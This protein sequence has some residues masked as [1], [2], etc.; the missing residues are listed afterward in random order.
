MI[1]Y[2]LHML[3]RIDLNH[4]GCSPADH[5]GLAMEAEEVII[6]EVVVTQ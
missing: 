1:M 2:I 3:V 6:V 4:D 5:G